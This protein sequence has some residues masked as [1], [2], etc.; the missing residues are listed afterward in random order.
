M[1]DAPARLRPCVIAG[2]TRPGDF[3]V[4]AA[5]G[6]TVGRMYRV[7]SAQTETW[8]WFAHFGRSP[9]GR[10]SSREEAKRQFRAAWD[11]RPR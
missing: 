5:E 10:T 4:V 1:P 6:E 7:D 11:A 2:E 3:C 8:A 9:A